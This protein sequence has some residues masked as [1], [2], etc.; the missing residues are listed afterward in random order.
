M[1]RTAAAAPAAPAAGARVESARP[2]GRLSATF[3]AWAALGLGTG[4]A[5]AVT[6]PAA[7][8][9]KVFTVLS[10]SMEP[11]LRTGDLVVD[12]QIAPL[13]ANVGDVV[14]FKDPENP[15]RLVTHRVRRMRVSGASVRFV[16]KGDRNNAVERW[17]VPADGLIG[18]VVYRVPKLGYVTAHAGS[19]VGLLT[20]VVVPAL[21][22]GALEL[23]RIWSSADTER[24]DEGEA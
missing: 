7:L 18:R 9:H 14:T 19:R 16:T 3:A 2:L 11:T 12:E 1:S 24:T 5:L 13:E 10:G 23:K 21:L 6:A 20:L 4:L 8:G 22:L 17:S 15:A